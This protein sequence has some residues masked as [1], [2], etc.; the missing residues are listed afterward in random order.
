MPYRLDSNDQVF[1]YMDEFYC[2]SNFS[3][4]RLIWRGRDFD[5]SE[6]A[7]Q[8]EKFIEHWSIFKLIHDARSAHEAFKIA[9][10]YKDQVY[11]GWHDI[12]I[13]IMKKIL[14]A[15]INQHKYVLKKL[16]DTGHRTIIEDSWRDSFWGWGPNKNGKNMLGI[17]WMEIRNELKLNINDT[18]RKTGCQY[19]TNSPPVAS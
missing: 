13:E 17:L 3:A 19:S 12:K 5:T 10:H 7:Y 4:F 14:K 18:I 11:P 1:C 9:E 15:K 16:M 8:S 2:L 6:A